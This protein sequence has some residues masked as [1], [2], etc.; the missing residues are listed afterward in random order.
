MG[1]EVT[2]RPCT[3]MEIGHLVG[4]YHEIHRPSMVEFTSHLDG[5]GSWSIISDDLP[6]V[7]FECVLVGCL[8]LLP[9][10][11]VDGEIVDVAFLIWDR[12]F[13]S[14]G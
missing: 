4:I 3:C 7:A 2:H 11:Q 1:T 10:E 5:F 14:G 6:S 9:I 8:E 13:D 12:Q